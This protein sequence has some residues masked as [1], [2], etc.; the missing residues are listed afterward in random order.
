[1]VGVPDLTTTSPHLTCG[2]KKNKTFYLSTCRFG[3]AQLEIA[4]VCGSDRDT[5]TGTPTLLTPG[6]SSLGM[7]EALTYGGAN[8]QTRFSTPFSEV[9]VM[10]PIHAAYGS[11]GTE[12]S[13]IRSRIRK[14]L[15]GFVAGGEA[16]ITYV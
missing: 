2:T 14:C 1:M 11:G 4:S 3:S 6:M 13:K 12:D 5:H 7:M 16:K 15:L 9:K 10:N 8:K